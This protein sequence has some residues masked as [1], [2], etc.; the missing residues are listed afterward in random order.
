[1]KKTTKSGKLAK[2][3]R[4]LARRIKQ[5]SRMEALVALHLVAK[6]TQLQIK[7][8]PRIRLFSRVT[9][10][11]VVLLVITGQ[12]ARYIKSRESE[13]KVNGQAILVAEKVQEV[14]Q[15]Q[16]DSFIIVKKSPFD[17]HKPVEGVISQ[18][19]SAYHR[20]IDI[21]APFGSPI[22]PVGKGTVE[23][24][25]FEADGKGNVVIVDHGD[26]LK[27]LYA[28]MNRIDVSVGNQVDTNMVIG[29]IGLTGHTT[30][31]HVHL[32]IYDNGIMVD[33]AK[34]LPE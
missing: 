29:T 14:P 6:Y 24:A 8:R 33:P 26:G 10:A 16:I 11:L 13:I 15:T 1:M 23:F 22:Q 12:I 34:V 32:E 7:I 17:L 5:V 3:F 4:K 9:L 28:H 27:S 20:A 25:G 2:S 30:G 31:P 19:Y 21:A 18:G